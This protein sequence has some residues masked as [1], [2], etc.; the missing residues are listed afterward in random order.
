[1]ASR[2]GLSKRE[3]KAAKSGGSLNYS[4]GKVV[5]PKQVAIK[6]HTQKLIQAQKSQYGPAK[7]SGY[8][9]LPKGVSGPAAPK[10]TLYNNAL[11][12]YNQARKNIQAGINVQNQVNSVKQS[13]SF[14]TATD[15]LNK[16]KQQKSEIDKY[17]IPT[18][19]KSTGL[20]FDKLKNLPTNGVKKTPAEMRADEIH[21]AIESQRPA[22][23]N[24]NYGGSVDNRNNTEYNKGLL[25]RPTIN[26]NSLLFQRDKGSQARREA[27]ANMPFSVKNSQA[28]KKKSVFNA[29]E[30]G[31][32]IFE[33]VTKPSGGRGGFSQE[34]LDK[35]GIDP[36]NPKFS[37]S[38]WKNSIVGSLRGAAGA[39]SFVAKLPSYGAE[40]ASRAFGNNSEAD[41]IKKTREESSL[42]KKLD[43]FYQ[44]PSNPEQAAASQKAEA[45]TNLY[46][47]SI[48]S[49]RGVTEGVVKGL[50]Q[51]TSASVIKNTLKNASE[52][53]AKLSDE[54]IDSLSTKI[55]HASSEEEVL[56]L[57]N[58]V[59]NTAP[60]ILSST[61][62]VA[63]GTQEAKVA[64]RP[65]ETTPAVE[66]SQIP[67]AKT[68]EP[69]LT[70]KFPKTLEELPV[71][72]SKADE[73]YRD[74]DETGKEKIYVNVSDGGKDLKKVE[75]GEIDDLGNFTEKLAEDGRKI[76]DVLEENS[77][78]LRA[79]KGL[80]TRPEG[81][82]DGRAMLSKFNQGKKKEGI[83]NKKKLS[84][85]ADSKLAQTA[86][87]TQ[88]QDYLTSKIARLQEALKNAKNPDTYARISDQLAEES[89]I[90]E[91]YGKL[92]P[93]GRRSLLERLQREDHTM[94]D[95]ITEDY[96]STR[97]TAFQPGKR[98]K[99]SLVKAMEAKNFTKGDG[100]KFNGSKTVYKG[101]SDLTTKILTDLE[102]RSTVSRKYIE[103]ATNRGDIK[104]AERDLIRRIL[105][106]EGPD[107]DVKK[108]AEKVKT[109]LLPLERS[110]DVPEENKVMHRKSQ[111]VLP[112]EI[113]GTIEKET[114]HVYGSPIKVSTGNH[115]KN[116]KYPNYFAH[117]RIEDVPGGTRRVIEIQSDL[118]QKGRLENEKLNWKTVLYN[119]KEYRIENRFPY[120]PALSDSEMMANPKAKFTLKEVKGNSTIEVSGTELQKIRQY[121]EQLEPYHN[122]WHERVI[123][124]ELKKAA[125]DGKRSVQFPTG[126]TAM[127]IEGLGQN[128]VFRIGEGTASRFV[129]TEDLKVG[130][131]ISQGNPGG[132]GRNEWI[133]TDVLG[134]GKFKAV[135]KDVVG[136]TKLI[137]EDDIY[138]FRT[139]PSTSS[140]EESFDI[141]G[142]VDTENPIY[143]FYEK[144]VQKYLNKFG[145]KVVTDKQGVKWVEVPV[146]KEMGSKPVTAFAN[147]SGAGA[148]FEEGEDGKI[149]YNA[150]KGLLGLGAGM[151]GMKGAKVL[152]KGGVA[153]EGF[154]ASQYVKQM[155]KQ[156]RNAEGKTTGLLAKTKSFLAEF[157]KKAVD[158]NAPIEDLIAQQQKKLN[159]EAIPRYDITNAI[160]RVYRSTSMAGAFA[161]ENGL[162]KVIKQV[163][164]L[165]EFDQYLIAKHG[166]SLEKEG[167]Q[168]GRDASKDRLL[169]EAVGD[170]YKEAEKTVR[171]YSHKLMD[172]AVES[173][174]ISRKIA[175]DLKVKYPDY[176]PYNRIFGEDEAVSKGTGGG[177][178][179]LG[180]QSVVQKIKG[181]QREVQSPMRSFLEKTTTAFQQGEK[182]KTAQ[183][184]TS[185][186][187]LPDNP[188]GLEKIAGT[189]SPGDN[190][191][192]VFKD[193]VK[194]IWKVNKDIA[195]A[196]KSLNVEQMGLLGKMFA[197]PVRIAKLGITGINLPFV[198]ANAAK[199]VVS[200]FVM[201][202]HPFRSLMAM[203]EALF[204][205]VGHGKLYK[206]MLKEGAMQT[207]FDIARNQV[208]P[209][210]RNTRG[211][212][213]NKG[214]EKVKY[215]ADTPAKLFRAIEDIIGRSEELNRI[216][217]YKGAYKGAIAKGMKP[218]DARAVASRASRENSVNFARKGEYGSPM[219]ALVLYLNA[220]IQG[221][222]TLVRNLKTNPIQTSAKILATVGMPMAITTAWN[223]SDPKRKEAYMDLQDYEKENNFIYIPSNP[224]KDENGKWN[225]VK[226]PIQPGLSNLVQ[227]IRYALEKAH[228]IDS[229]SFGKIASQLSGVVSPIQV[230]YNADSTRKAVGQLIPQAIKPTVEVQTNTDMFTGGKI[231]PRKL[232]GLDSELQVKDGTSGTAKILGKQLGVSPLQVEHF[233]KASLG[234]VGLQYLNA[235]DRV[236]AKTGKISTDEI[237]GQNV[238]QA[239]TGRFNKAFGGAVENA[240]WEQK[241]QA[242]E[243]DK[244]EKYVAKQDFMP[245]YT[246][247][248]ELYK[249]GKDQ[250]ADTILQNMN[251]KD[252]E[253][254]QKI[255]TSEKR[256][257]T[258]EGKANFQPKYDK[259]KKLYQEGKD[260]EA[261][262]MLNSLSED[263]LHY[264]ELLT[265]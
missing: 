3:V 7:I 92:Q 138:E 186:H 209:T 48:K 98:E 125:Q 24:V 85:S 161:K 15:L 93:E 215:I 50:A 70:D 164:D 30:I 259:L 243:K 97:E 240:V 11:D 165:D 80:S 157:K 13:Q 265:K 173:G 54:V 59:D 74:V 194:E 155:A 176:V 39:G 181:S 23:K 90:L 261:D 22:T 264:L 178:A 43:Q 46:G 65:R 203:P 53:F 187:N 218:I 29:P 105:D 34:Q 52:S 41:F 202:K 104:Q 246:K 263:E 147:A 185:F 177:V 99:G 141:S 21:N 183:I 149:R 44:N 208:S 75:I 245:T 162:E 103:D 250:E 102:G 100:G 20:H 168:T 86:Q 249:Q 145:G 154:N 124:E 219:N 8:Q 67:M 227:P 40:Y 204:Q 123:R 4:T 18:T 49:G 115:F 126:E 139:D 76:S 106:D 27:N 107:V 200:A 230:P 79:G 12:Q 140:Y 17:K 96:Q 172:Y 238:L 211:L 153:K 224:T 132:A 223:L 244:S 63:Q 111:I 116:D 82:G 32:S 19:P 118:F 231:I 257:K 35:S 119:G 60:Q 109:E 142:K 158:T 254:F 216:S 174:L 95:R 241:A 213:G 143:K 247:V 117:S 64:E 58:T 226:I 182:N 68:P 214:I 201:S 73:I 193:G 129:D 51:E 101:E 36:R 144:T 94:T 206:E 262:A 84:A 88:A 131:E 260:D 205:A 28:G 190:T 134:D 171:D 180:S 159:F 45:L 169:I 199:D 146:T 253:Q 38:S 232:E 69:T 242:S 151:I 128:D 113:R 71:K 188:F 166:L 66:D 256:K 239:I 195:D 229:A 87:D 163:D 14:K 156:Q 167:I 37:G 135:P 237:G 72:S 108:F 207:S 221:S 47:G 81:N 234:S 5:L 31:K 77:R 175:D 235:S 170:K 248:Q 130:A 120:N 220:G 212:I 2:N 228:Q 196:A 225:V 112:D 179:S 236:L 258:V 136:D 10:Q 152:S 114:E 184:L 33:E 62:E 197:A 9:A 255:A 42:I 137:T 233:V 78:N 16:K 56:S 57:M 198:A 210:V 251:E 25:R 55:A 148:G 217:Q 91:N 1:M 26:N 83:L 6:T 122:T 189:K 61:D 252:L 160:D 89:S 192:S 133:I 222:R 150:E 110:P 127:K 121:G 191:I